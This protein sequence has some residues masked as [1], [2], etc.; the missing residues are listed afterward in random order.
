[1]SNE[2]TNQAAWLAFDRAYNA[3]KG[4][5]KK[6]EAAAYAARAAVHAQGVVEGPAEFAPAF[7]ARSTAAL[8]GLEG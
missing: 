8:A 6:K 1:M 7:S 4:S 5:R 3:T 2:T